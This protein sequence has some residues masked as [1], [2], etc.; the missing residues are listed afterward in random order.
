MPSRQIQSALHR[1]GALVAPWPFALL[2]A[3]WPFAP[4]LFAPLLLVVAGCGGAV[5]KYIPKPVNAVFSV[6]PSARTIDTNGKLRMK[7]TAASG[8]PAAVKWSVLGGDNDPSLGEGAIDEDGNYTPPA[9]LT[10]D[11]IQVELQAQLRSD[12]RVAATEVIAVT[13]SFLQPLTPE[14]STLAAGASVEV[15]AQLAEVGGGAVRWQ[16]AASPSGGSGYGTFSQQSCQRSPRDYTVCSAVYTAPAA[17]PD[18]E[19]EVYVIASAANATEASRLPLH[20][21]FSDSGS[22]STPLA[23]QSAQAS[24]VQLGAS[25]GNNNDADT[26]DSANGAFINDCCGGTLGALVRDEIGGQYILSNNHVLAE[27]DQARIGDAIVQP[28]LIDRNC[29][30]NAGRSVATLRY[31]V[32]LASPATNSDAALAEVNAGTVDP[33]GAILQLGSPSAGANGSIGAAPPAA[34]LGQAPTPDLFAP[35]SAP[36]LVAKSGR[37][38]GLTCSAIDAIDLSVEVDYYKDCAETQPYYRKTF[39]GQLGIS[40]AGFSDSGDSGA[41]VVNAANAE[42]L[43]LYFAGGAGDNGRGL[44]IA[45]PIQDVL[46]ELDA[47][48]GHQFSIVGGAEHPVA[49][50]NY[51]RRTATAE[52]IP[53]GLRK[54]ADAA[55]RKGGATLVNPALGVLELA[56]GASS[57]APGAP[58]IIVYVDKAKENVAVPQTIAGLRTVV[59]PADEASLNAGAAPAPKPNDLAE[60]IRLPAAVLESAQQ[61]Q[62]AYAAQLMA[63]PAV[64][65]VGV[66][67]SR[68][69][70]QEAALLVLVDPAQTPLSMPAVVGGLRTRYLAMRRFHVTKSKYA[71]APHPS[72]CALRSA[73]AASPRPFRLP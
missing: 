65:G 31:A 20:I 70:P 49:C 40:G 6:T 1:T 30:Q 71:A 5:S 53:E 11:S 44:S 63:D 57:D 9:A 48:A 3:P 22:S 21:L 54:K 62:H 2:F 43:G 45:T 16:L 55:I 67:Q 8:A 42:P 73:A 51:D 47:E 68:D 69:N 64:F 24:L 15:T 50:L 12:P 25:G 58:A 66:T 28:A 10:R 41:L 35:D 72:S 46:R 17:L 36:L 38:T 59:V 32:P 14:N 33:T 52:P 4:L 34:G 29:D 39:S 19:K 27:S 56:A 60:G 23:N 7:A 37:T 18:S 26:S 13:P 61:V